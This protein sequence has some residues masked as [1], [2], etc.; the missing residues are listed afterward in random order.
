VNDEE[1]KKQVKT[2]RQ[3]KW[4]IFFFKAKTYYRTPYPVG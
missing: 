3:N 4:L 2:K 1:V